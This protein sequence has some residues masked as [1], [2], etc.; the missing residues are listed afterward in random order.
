MKKKKV[1]GG[2]KNRCKIIMTTDLTDI[3]ESFHNISIL[4]ILAFTGKCL[5]PYNFIYI[6]MTFFFNKITPYICTNHFLFNF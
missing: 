3:L 6:N 5:H 2:S 1:K 4:Y